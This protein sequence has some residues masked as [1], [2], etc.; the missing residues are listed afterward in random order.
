MS[1]K[2]TESVLEEAILEYLA[3]LKWDILFGP[4]IVPGEPV[5]ER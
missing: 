2:F 1:Q 5:V 4:E 3:S